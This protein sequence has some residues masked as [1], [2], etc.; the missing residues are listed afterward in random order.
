MPV[1]RGLP[2]LGNNIALLRDAQKMI[3]TGQARHRRCMQH[4]FRRAALAGYMTQ[5]NELAREH[6][7]AATGP[8][9]ADGIN[10]GIALT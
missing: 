10:E 7:A 8:S 2:L 1:L 3:L 9:G 6:V 5:I 4:A